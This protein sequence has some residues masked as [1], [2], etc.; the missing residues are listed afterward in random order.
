MAKVVPTATRAEGP[1]ESAASLPNTSRSS[2]GPATSADTGGQGRPDERGDHDA[3]VEA[4][5]GVVTTGD[6]EVGDA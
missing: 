2:G 3:T 5:D 4:S 1:E 6:H